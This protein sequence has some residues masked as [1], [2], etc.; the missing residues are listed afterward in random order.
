MS[1]DTK[2][3]ICKWCHKYIRYKYNDVIEKTD[4][5]FGR[6]KNIRCPHCGR[7]TTVR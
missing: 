1:D 6:C 7:L 5:V 2:N 3:T 4:R